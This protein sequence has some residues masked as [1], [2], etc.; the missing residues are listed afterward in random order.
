[1]GY[2]GN[3]ITSPVSI[4]DV[5]Q[6]LNDGSNDLGTL[7][8]SNN[9]A[10]WARWRPIEYS[11]SGVYVKPLTV[12]QRRSVNWGIKNIPIW[13][14][15]D[16]GKV[17]AVWIDGSTVS[18]NAPDC[19]IQSNYWANNA[20][21]TAFRLT[22][23]V[24]PT[25]PTSIGYFTN[26]HAPISS[27]SS[28]SKSS[29]VITVQFNMDLGGIYSGQTLWYGDFTVMNNISFKDNL[30]FGIVMKCD[31]Q[32]FLATQDN[33]VGDLG[34]TS[35]TLWSMGAHVRFKVSSAS[36]KLYTYINNY[37]PIKMFPVLSS[38][39]NY[40]ESTVITAI[41]P[42]STSG[43]FVAVWETEE[44]TVP[45][46]IRVVPEIVYFY[47]WKDASNNKR[48]DYRM[49]V[50]TNDD[51]T[52]AP[53]R[54]NVTLTALNRLGAQT[55]NQNNTTNV[56]T[57]YTANT[58]MDLGSDTTSGVTNMRVEIEKG[59]GDT[60]TDFASLEMIYP[61]LDSEPPAVE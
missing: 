5:Q 45:G 27:V 49:L 35:A 44:Q 51:S 12:A 32:V 38:V 39:K 52:S 19:G 31:D 21:T 28:I 46:A 37:T 14:G 13:T 29:S 58:Y 7:C 3:T 6:A 33:K 8:R 20:P 22:D 2:N 10:T 60:S 54:I 15:K 23:F 55:G 53:H 50:V 1:M 34:T 48:I 24:S 9:I 25:S 18:S 36:G 47:A 59:Q 61:V 41:T 11:Q 30:Y 40:V 42:A 43:N 4:A 16:L 26:A 56:T 17:V 57:P